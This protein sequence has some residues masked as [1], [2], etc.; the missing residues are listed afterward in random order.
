M[1]K[2]QE[3]YPILSLSN[4]SVNICFWRFKTYF[5]FRKLYWRETDSPSSNYI[6]SKYY[7]NDVP[8]Q[9]VQNAAS[10][11]PK[12]GW[13]LRSKNIWINRQSFQPQPQLYVCVTLL[14]SWFR[15]CLANFQGSFTLWFD[16]ID[17]KWEDYHS[18][19]QVE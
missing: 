19:R 6:R 15:K 17:W 11:K 3:H 4:K 8:L 2:D 10:I 14:T 16:M 13:R 9:E 5:I 7:S 1:I 18:R 12:D